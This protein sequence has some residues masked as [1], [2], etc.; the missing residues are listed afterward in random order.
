MNMK[1][2]LLIVFTVLSV[3]LLRPLPVFAA[4]PF[5]NFGNPFTIL[6][7][8]I[9]EAIQELNTRIDGLINN[10]VSGPA[11]ATGIQGDSGQ[12]GPTGPTG[13]IGM[14]GPIGA[15]GLVGEIGPQGWTGVAG[16]TGGTGPIGATGAQ[17]LLGAGNVAFITEYG[18]LTNDGTVWRW[19]GSDWL[20][21]NKDVPIPV[22]NIVQFSGHFFLDVNGDVWRQ[23]GDTWINTGHP[24]FGTPT[25]T[26]TSF[27]TPTPTPSLVILLDDEFNNS[28]LDTNTWEFFSTN[29]GTY[30]FDNDSIVVPG[31]S[32]MFYIRTK[33]NPFPVTGQFT[34]EFGIQY[35]GVDESGVGVALGFEQQNGYDQSN[36][37]V[38]YWQDHNGLV[39]SRFGLTVANMSGV[40]TNY[41][42][43]KIV[44]D[45]DKYQV[46]LD[47]VLKYTSP[48][49]LTAKSLWFGNPF[50]CRTNWTGFKLDYIKVT[51][52]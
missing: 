14:T 33:N 18:I 7:N 36:I 34:A 48:S 15:S 13:A 11:G 23:G 22:S 24:S 4:S 32:S 17:G 39:V 9:Y 44:Y 26:P 2:R 12:S 45:G 50:C 49:S 1:M 41:H 6:F 29:G 28:V 27:P 42:I 47:S 21:D 40:N 30:S 16:T 25:P 5:D 35:T 43:G 20:E 38:S 52:P 8:A 31:G 3:I 46:F 10:P 19:S 37:P 51:Q